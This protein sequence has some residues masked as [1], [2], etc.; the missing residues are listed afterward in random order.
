MPNSLFVRTLA[1]ST[2]IQKGAGTATAAPSG[3]LHVSTT[4]AGT[5]ADTNETDLWSYA[6]PANTLS[7]DGKALRIRAWGTTGATANTK[8]LRLYV[9]A[10]AL[11]TLGPSGYNNLGW[12]IDAIVVRTGA[13]AQLAQ[14]FAAIGVI[15]GAVNQ[16]TTPAADTT[17][18]ITL[19]V[20][21]QNGT[22]AA[23]DVVL[24]GAIV[25]ALN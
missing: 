7:A 13:S 17:A 24:K 21:G 25:E 14:T 8:T 3:V 19:K 22:A 1:D 16:G 12:H 2:T 11:F 18:A 15:T 20:T 5:I 4:Q 6:L 23:N 10:T 9:G